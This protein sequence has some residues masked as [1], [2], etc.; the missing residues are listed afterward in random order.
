MVDLTTSDSDCDASDMTSHDV[1]MTD[2]FVASV[3]LHGNAM[4]VCDW[5]AR[6]TDQRCYDRVCRAGGNR[7]PAPA[8]I[9]I[10]GSLLALKLKIKPLI[11]SGIL[12]KDLSNETTY[13]LEYQFS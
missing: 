4:R 12:Q 5:M 10:P 9:D 2:V 13:C 6:E 1:E 11:M 7:A 8:P 3:C